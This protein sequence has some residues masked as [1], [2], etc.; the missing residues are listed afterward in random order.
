M[1][2]IVGL[3]NHRTP[4][5]SDE[6]V[7]LKFAPNWT[8]PY[9]IAVNE[10]LP[11]LQD[12]PDWIARNNFRVFAG[13]SQIDPSAVDWASLSASNFGYTLRQDP[14]ASSALGLVRF[15]L[16]NDFS[17]FLHDTGSRHLFARAERSMSHGCV[18][19]GD[20]AALAEFAL[21]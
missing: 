9:K 2:V 12:D 19:V 11:K 16:T 10:I 5:F 20:P 14:S 3:P 17:I 4:I 1:P 6:I 21:A 15:S 13:S 7:N 8:V 18:R